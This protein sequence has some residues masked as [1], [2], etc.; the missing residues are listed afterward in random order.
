MKHDRVNDLVTEWVTRAVR[1]E[2]SDL[3]PAPTVDLL[4]QQSFLLS[5]ILNLLFRFALRS[6]MS[7]SDTIR[8]Q[9]R[10]N[11]TANDGSPR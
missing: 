5:T 1:N 11:Q 4:P 7:A 8:T 6:I 3:L 2:E 9:Q 10:A